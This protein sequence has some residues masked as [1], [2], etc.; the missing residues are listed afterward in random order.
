MGTCISL[1]TNLNG[2]FVGII[3]NSYLFVWD[4][5]FE[6]MLCSIVIAFVRS[7]I[8]KMGNCN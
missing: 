4:L 1:F 8:S 7:W 5:K 2:S 6:A 3:E